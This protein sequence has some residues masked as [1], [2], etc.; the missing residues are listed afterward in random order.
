LIDVNR[1]D[2][3]DRDGVTYLYTH[4]Y[5]IAALANTAI[6]S[7]LVGVVLGAVAAWVVK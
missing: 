3:E 1:V 5:F 4:D 2:V 6:V 7:F